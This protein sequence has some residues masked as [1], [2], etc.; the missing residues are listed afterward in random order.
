MRRRRILISV[1][2]V[3]GFLVAVALGLV[4]LVKREPAFYRQAEVAAGEPRVAKSRS[5]LL[6][7]SQL[8]NAL[9]YDPEWQATLSAD[10][11][12]AYFQEDFLKVGADDNLPD[13]F[14]APRVQ[15]G[16][17]RIRIGVRYGSG[18]WSTILSVELKAWLIPGESNNM[19]GVEV[20]GLRAGAMPLSTSTLLDYISQ[21]ARRQ[22]IDVTW[23]RNDGHPVAVMRSQ[24]DVARPTLLFERLDLAEGSVT[25]RGRL[26]D[27]VG[28]PVVKPVLRGP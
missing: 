6:Q 16:D 28:V 14:H 26:A 12:N 3:L 9:M 24:A 10:E 7:F 11:I 5:A 27:T 8:K 19:I 23:Y 20:V 25:L 17:G 1:C 4:A 22:G 18:L 21:G 15:I 13:D 2:L